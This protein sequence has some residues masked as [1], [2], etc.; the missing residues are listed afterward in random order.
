MQVRFCVKNNKGKFCNSIY[1]YS[2]SNGLSGEVLV[3]N[4]NINTNEI[5]SEQ[6]FFAYLMNGTI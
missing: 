4:F 5:S 6:H 2:F 1:S 3:K